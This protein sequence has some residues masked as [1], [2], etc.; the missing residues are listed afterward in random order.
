MKQRSSHRLLPVG[1]L[2]LGILVLFGLGQV[3][4]FRIDLTEEKRYSLHPSTLQLL[5]GIDRPLHVDIL[6]TGEDLPGGMRRLQKS[7]EETVRTFNAYSAENIT[8]SYFDP[9]EVTDSLKEDF[10]FTLA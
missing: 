10:I 6:L 9:M 7:V 3:L 5:E 2:V 1:I 8:V 4:R